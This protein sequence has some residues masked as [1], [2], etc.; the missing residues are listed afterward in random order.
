MNNNFNDKY[1]CLL[2]IAFCFLIPVFLLYFFHNNWSTTLGSI[3]Y[4]LGIL[5][6]FALWVYKDSNKTN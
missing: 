6:I 5:G 4:L 2:F 1:G 3:S